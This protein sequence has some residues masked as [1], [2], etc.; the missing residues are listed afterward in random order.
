M[1]F[2]YGNTPEA[3][4]KMARFLFFYGWQSYVVFNEG[5]VVARG[6]WD[7][8]AASEVIFDHR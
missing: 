8:T 5:S 3:V 4:A 7:T 1:T 2:L 6:E